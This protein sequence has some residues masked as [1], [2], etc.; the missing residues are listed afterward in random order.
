MPRPRKLSTDSNRMMLPTDSVVATMI[1][2]TTLGRMCTAMMR[3]GPAPIERAAVTNS[4]A[5]MRSAS[6]RTSRATVVQPNSATMTTMR[7]R[8]TSSDCATAGGRP[9]FSRSTAASTMS[10]GSS[11]RAITPSVQRIR[12]ASSRPPK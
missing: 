12:K 11:G 5:R 8:L 3:H 4:R 10:S 6:A 7:Y 2:E 1:G 9:S